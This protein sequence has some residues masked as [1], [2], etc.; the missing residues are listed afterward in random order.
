MSLHFDF[1]QF[2]SAFFVLF[3]IIDIIG[4]MPVM[5]SLKRRGKKINPLKAAIMGFFAFMIF[6][7]VGEAFLKLFGVDISSFAVAGS[8]IIF[9]MALEMVLDINI[10]KETE[11]SPKDSTFFPVVFPLIAGAGSLTTILSLRSQIFVFNIVLAVAANMFVVYW[12]LRFVKKLEAV[13]GAGGMYMIK[14]FFG[15]ILLAISVKL[16]TVNLT[17]IIE[18]FVNR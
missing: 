13:L 9:V 15:I 5:L 17:L 3:A 12:V 8:L 14:K 7:F 16:F 11:D 4:T 6:L 18:G 2:L 10:F 1:Q